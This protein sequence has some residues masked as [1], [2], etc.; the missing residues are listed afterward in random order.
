[1][2]SPAKNSHAARKPAPRDRP[3]TGSPLQ[4]ETVIRQPHLLLD[5]EQLGNFSH[6][7]DEPPGNAC[8]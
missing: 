7:M 2:A 3:R 5:V 8:A 1:M 4:V 6:G